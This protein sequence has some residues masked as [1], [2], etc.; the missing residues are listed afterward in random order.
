VFYNQI[1]LYASEYCKRDVEID[2]SPLR[3]T[4]VIYQNPLILH[5]YNDVYVIYCH[6]YITPS[7]N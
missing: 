5:E 4:P 1:I 7:Q 3:M 2:S 6:D